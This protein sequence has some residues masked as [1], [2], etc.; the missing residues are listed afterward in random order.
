[1]LRQLTSSKFRFA[2]EWTGVRLSWMT[3]ELQRKNQTRR[4]TR[5][6]HDARFGYLIQHLWHS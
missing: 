3:K 2:L 5:K 6:G 1:M 4:M